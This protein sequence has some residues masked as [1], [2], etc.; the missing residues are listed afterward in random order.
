M[1]LKFRLHQA[2]AATSRRRTNRSALFLWITCLV[3]ALDLCLTNGKK[4]AF[5]L[6]QFLQT[7]PTR[8]LVFYEPKVKTLTALV[9]NA[10]EKMDISDQVSDAWDFTVALVTLVCV[11]QVIETTRVSVVSRLRAPSA[12]QPM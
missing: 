7:Y 9:N 10:I 11:H 8:F 12:K 3:V 5:P 6:F 2:V 4:V 1:K